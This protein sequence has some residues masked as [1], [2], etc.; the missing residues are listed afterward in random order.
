[1]EPA[2]FAGATVEGIVVDSKSSGRPRSQ[3][4]LELRINDLNYNRQV[5]ALA[6]RIT[7]VRNSRGE[8]DRDEGG[9][10]LKTKEGWVSRG[11]DSAEKI[12]SAV[13][14]LFGIGRGRD[15]RASTL[16]LTAKAPRITLDSGSEFDLH[17][18][19]EDGQ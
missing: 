9:H 10:E 8:A 15:N 7:G 16:K 19:Q 3:S 2:E 4:N 17:M 13:V 14:G 1:M 5:L 11:K 12:G 6:C 18:V